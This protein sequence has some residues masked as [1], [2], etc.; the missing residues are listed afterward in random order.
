MR[1][2]ILIVLFFLMFIGSAQA[3]WIVEWDVD[4]S[5]M[6]PCE[7]PNSGFDEFGREPSQVVTTTLQICWETKINHM[8][9]S[10]DNQND[11]IKFMARGKESNTGWKPNLWNF[12][13]YFSN[14][15]CPDIDIKDMVIG[16]S[17]YD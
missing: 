13:I 11:A 1:K 6:I 14:A 4:N 3:G 8:K 7:Q 9:K 5:Y 16:G 12:E 17:I 15:H 2:I 10:F